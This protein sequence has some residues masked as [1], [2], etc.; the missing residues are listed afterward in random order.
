MKIINQY[1]GLK[2]E[3]YILVI[4][5]TVTA[6]GSFVWPILSFFMTLRL[7]FTDST[8]SLIMAVFMIF[9]LPASIIGGKLTDKIGRKKVIVF[10]D[11]ATVI[12]YVLT[13]LLPKGIASIIL[14]FFAGLFQTMES[15]AYDALTADN[16]ESNNRD[17]AYS[18]TYLGFNLGFILGASLAGILFNINVSLCFLLNAVSILISTILIMI[19]IKDKYHIIKDDSELD[20]AV[21]NEYEKPVPNNTSV[22]TILKSMR[23]VLL[24]IILACFIGLTYNAVGTLVPLQLKTNLGGYG[25]TIYGYLSST[26]GVVVIFFTPILTLILKKFPEVWKIM[27]SIL[28]FMGGM[29]LFGFTTSI[30]C[31][32]IAM[33]VHTLGEVTNSIGSQPYIGRRIPL[34]HRGRINGIVSACY[35]VMGFLSQL[36]IS[37]ILFWTNNNYQIIWI[38]YLSIA[39]VCF[40]C[41]IIVKKKDQQR[42]PLLYVKSEKKSL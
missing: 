39:A 17:K 15:P 7:G 5:K 2:K 36:L 16:S 23:V 9:T 20:V 31:A 4:G 12:L 1:K 37:G 28:F 32:F 24:Y 19:F 30:I 25:A 3:I 26:N 10:F 42:F 22:W 11:F 35:S 13:A 29:I 33:V 34:S 38:V 41:F 14:I 8:A 27:L 6:M 18:L 40:I 21:S